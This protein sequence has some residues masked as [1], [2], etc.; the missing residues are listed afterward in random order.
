MTKKVPLKKIQTG[1]EKERAKRVYP[2]IY[3][4]LFIKI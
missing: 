2:E 1:V 3:N 4:E